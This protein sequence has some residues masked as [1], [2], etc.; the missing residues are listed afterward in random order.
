MFGRMTHAFVLSSD[1]R[2]QTA[3]GEAMRSSQF[4]V[5][6]FSTPASLIMAV[7]RL[8]AGGDVAVI[9]ATDP[10]AS[11]IPTLDGVEDLCVTGA[12]VGEALPRRWTPAADAGLFWFLCYIKC[13]LGHHQV[14]LYLRHDDCARDLGASTESGPTAPVVAVETTDRPRES[15]GPM[16]A[17]PEW[18]ARLRDRLNRGLL[19]DYESVEVEWTG[20]ALVLSGQVLSRTRRRRAEQLVR[21]TGTRLRVKNHLDV[22]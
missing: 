7:E 5:L 6:S 13:A 9:D 12:I 22:I 1:L 2:R 14:G 20:K 15:A 17:S 19:T 18:L 16:E 4:E 8:A 3:I 10:V 11:L 21:D